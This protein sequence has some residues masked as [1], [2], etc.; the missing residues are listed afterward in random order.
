MA[1][2]GSTVRNPPPNKKPP[3]FTSNQSGFESQFSDLSAFSACPPSSKRPRT[4]TGGRQNINTAAKNKTPL[5]FDFRSTKTNDNKIIPP[6]VPSSSTSHQRYVSKPVLASQMPTPKQQQGPVDGF[7]DSQDDWGED[8]DDALLLAASQMVEP[9]AAKAE[10]N[11][12]ELLAMTAMLEDDDFGLD[13]VPGLEPAALEIEQGEAEPD[14]DGVH[15]VHLHPDVQ[16]ATSTRIP[17]Q[18]TGRNLLS[19]ELS[20]SL[21]RSVF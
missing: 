16:A 6:A 18:R 2:R 21:M 14:H 1:Y 11:E 10:T 15:P 4:N 8:G 20:P 17:T 7:D 3:P 9:V 19:V 13:D 12:E 5:K